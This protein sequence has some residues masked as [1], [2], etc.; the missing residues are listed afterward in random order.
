MGSL[1]DIHKRGSSFRKAM[2]SVVC[3]FG[4]R[5]QRDQAENSRRNFSRSRKIRFVAGRTLPSR[6]QDAQPAPEPTLGGLT[7]Q[8]TAF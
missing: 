2:R 3:F 5:D 8:G 7:C 1:C 4:N 6:M